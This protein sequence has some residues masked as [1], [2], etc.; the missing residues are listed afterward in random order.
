M[1]A[2]V[3]PYTDFTERDFHPPIHRTD[4]FRELGLLHPTIR[5]EGD[6]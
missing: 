1:R 3:S 2:Q 6:F 4:D 5:P